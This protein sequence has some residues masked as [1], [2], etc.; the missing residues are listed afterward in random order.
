MAKGNSDVNLTIRA[1]NEASKAIDSV[2]SALSDLKSAQ[3]GVTQES[4]KTGSTLEQ[5]GSA[6]TKLN[7]QVGGLTAYERVVTSLQRTGQQV[8]LVE[9]S[10][11]G[12]TQKQAELSSEIKKTEASLG[13]LTS[14]SAQL[15][16]TLSRQDGV[17]KAAADE[18]KRLDQAVKATASA[19]SKAERDATRYQ[20]QLQK[21]ETRLAGTQ[22][23]HRELTQELLRVESPTQRLIGQFERTDAALR[24]QSSAVATLRE[25]YAGS[26][27]SVL[28]LGSSLTRLQSDQAKAANSSR[29]AATAQA[30]T[31]AQLKATNAEINKSTGSLTKL[32]NSASRT[33][34]ELN[35][36]GVALEQARTDLGQVEAAAGE[37]S[38]AIDRVGQSIRQRLLR[39]LADSKKS[40]VD[41]RGEWERTTQVIRQMAAAGA[42]TRN[43]TPEMAKAIEDARAA[44]VAYQQTQQAVHQMR[45][46][47]RA[48]GTDVGALTR[49]Q[50]T[51]VNSL[52][53]IEQRSNGAAAAVNRTA[54]GMRETAAA[55]TRVNTETRK[56]ATAM[57][58]F[59][60]R[61]RSA[62]SITQRLRGEVLA[63][64]TAY[65]GLF[66]AIEEL[67]NVTGAFMQIEA[68]N[69][70]MLVAFN[71]NEAISGREMRFVREEADRLGIQFG[72]LAQEY[73]KF[74]IA[75]RGTALEGDEA[76]RIFLAVAEAARVNKL[77][78]D[79]MEGTYLALTQML[80]KG[81][82]SME[83]LRRQMG[84]R[85]YGAFNLAAEAMGLTT[86][87]LDKLVSTGQLA[88]ADF[89]P[90]FASELQRVFGPQLSQSLNTFTT[91]LGKFQNEIFK[92]RETVANAGFIDGLRE[93]IV[94][95]TAY[96]QSDEG[97]SFFENL[98]RA[99]GA[100]VQ[101]LARIPE[102]IQQI[103]FVFSLLI[104]M[105][106]AQ[107]LSG[108]GPRFAAAAAAMKPL[109]AA[110]QAT[111]RG[112]HGMALASNSAIPL[113]TRLRTSVSGMAVSFNTAA[114]GMTAARAG[115]L[116]VTG[117]MNG[118]R[119]ATAF[120][121]GPLG[122]AV[123]GISLGL[124]LWAG[125]TREATDALGEHQRQMIAVVDAYS[126]AKAGADDWAQSV[127]N[128]S[129]AGAEKNLKDLKE[130]LE[131]ELAEAARSLSG[132][133]TSSLAISGD[134]NLTPIERE[135]MN[136][137]GAAKQGQTSVR[138][139][140]T[141]LDRILKSSEAP[142]RL[143]SLI[144][145]SADLTQKALDTEK[146]L[147]SQGVVVGEL[148]GEVGDLLPLIQN[149][150]LSM[151]A[152]AEEA[153]LEGPIS[154][155]AVDTT[156]KLNELM[157]ALRDKTL[158]LKD[159]M[160]L[161]EGLSEIDDIL[162]T[163]DAIEGLDK[164]SE[165]YK[166]LLEIASQAK[167]E[168]HL[169]FDEKQF[170]GLQGLL[171][172][173]S[174]SVDTSAAL[175]RRFE[176]FRETPYWDVNADRVGYGS[177][178]V[179][180][181]D[182]SI[183]KVV[184]GMR[185]SIADANRDLERRIGEFQNTIRGQIGADRFASFSDQ[186]QAALTSIAYNYGSL[187]DR[188]IAAVREGSTA[189]IA[190][191][192]RGLSGDNE[193]VNRDRRNQEAFLFASG[194]DPHAQYRRDETALKDQLKV[195]QDLTREMERQQEKADQFHTRLNETLAL[196]QEE[197]ET[198]RK[199]TMEQEVQ[200][201]VSKA[202]MQARLAGT[203]L[204]EKQ[205]DLIRSN[206]EAEWQKLNAT[207]EQEEAE[208]RI[209]LLMQTRRDILQQMDMALNTGD[210]QTYDALRVQ[211]ETLDEKLKTL[212]T[213][214]ITM[215]EALGGSEQVGAAVANL[216]V[217][218][219]T[220]NA[221]QNQVKLMASD[222]GRAF[223][224]QLLT[225]ANNFLAKIRETGD[226]LGSAREAFLQ[227]AS[228]FLLQIAQMIM[229]QMLFNILS[230]AFGGSPAGS[231]GAGV[232]SVFKAHTGGVVGSGLQQSR[233]NSAMFANAVRYHTG[234][235]A[236]LRP[237]EVPAVLEKGEEVLTERD[238][239]HINNGGG[240]P[241]EQSVK[242]V[243]AI[244]AGSFISA[245]VEDVQGQ[246]AI[247]NFIQANKS[248]VRSALG[249]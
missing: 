164:T 36:Q 134:V 135:F 145:D 35:K 101:I 9:Q 88:S 24:K 212:I 228:D 111:T 58:L 97:V 59:G 8:A 41:Y 211:L 82:V 173:S 115:T 187:P 12:L 231:F 45:T 168:L 16:A 100:T 140:S 216:Q 196:K 39:E 76:R 114:R 3:A 139:L 214:A 15:E 53:Q 190:A 29:Q 124:S 192:I 51:F 122:L 225:G 170:K 74:A 57:D 178:T 194:D 105:R 103:T 245:G 107:W 1:K 146:A 221:V 87:E 176:G 238:P 148:G 248:S 77:S 23:K 20:N 177:D 179:T 138:D 165:A 55:A 155:G 2:S 200:L 66:G 17:T 243:N 186:Q 67:K 209:N 223:G 152:L 4:R 80:S 163:A 6:M 206:T 144:R 141:A 136:L 159:E 218:L 157:E 195:E 7:Q 28:D 189:E 244:D 154:E 70:R 126:T 65:L 208:K 137:V 224:D 201:A 215:W 149:L 240:A 94:R 169:A 52:A 84:D 120:L 232:M 32:Q 112:L 34:G 33:A 213:D 116:A 54:T 129:L 50:Q 219:G 151:S 106:V 207:R 234:G 166:R 191:S 242:I 64:A 42:S 130:Q 230:A 99:A 11:A 47:I 93:A 60:G 167:M 79:Q 102:Y 220:L 161:M 27:Q 46:A 90:K 25:S 182:G 71:G 203:E 156:A 113:I 18:L 205:R 10:V 117:A 247:L 197:A 86:A 110:V 147:A 19:Y 61:S 183:Q 62:M 153:G 198:D 5:L 233:A 22:A 75:A 109:P 21:T 38:I 229:K 172:G 73:S 89:L 91:D 217:M 249:V 92:A 49:A 133:I 180:L 235:I 123:T 199:R 96:F 241:A 121:G 69:N 85:L 81:A 239:R 188:I 210:M 184:Q 13:T 246:K 174:G 236:G 95:L 227:F 43:P 68:A 237:N 185:V 118:L 56:A 226:V 14:A 162:K 26:R 171:S 142:E 40:L 83:E 72:V 150:G 104:G 204:S 98:G 48:A 175:L 158:S 44:K 132:A 202:E 193:G 128:V 119:A 181:A 31:S 78:M 160:K 37:A 222:F 127:K 131:A 63:L 143:K 30:A 125:R 108:L